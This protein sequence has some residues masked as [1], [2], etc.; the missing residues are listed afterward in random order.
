MPLNEL[1]D[2]IKILNDEQAK[3]EEEINEAKRTSS[4]ASSNINDIQ[5]AGNTLPGGFF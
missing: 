3:E 1:Q 4:S 2:Y 5:M